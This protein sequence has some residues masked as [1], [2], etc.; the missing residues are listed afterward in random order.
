M[1]DIYKE[2]SDSVILEEIEDVLR[3]RRYDRL[4]EHQTIVAL[5]YLISKFKLPPTTGELDG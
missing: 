1:H 4:T 3:G 2:H 5:E